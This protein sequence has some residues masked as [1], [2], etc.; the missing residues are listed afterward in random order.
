MNK[1][2]LILLCFLGGCHCRLWESDSHPPKNV[3]FPAN[4]YTITGITTV[5]HQTVAPIRIY[6]SYLV[7]RVKAPGETEFRTL[8]QYEISIGTQAFDNSGWVKF[9][10]KVDLMGSSLILY[11]TPCAPTG[12]EYEIWSINSN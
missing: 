4:N 10:N 2:C 7:V 5:D 6:N 1:L 9:K 12:S 3:E 8:N 11:G